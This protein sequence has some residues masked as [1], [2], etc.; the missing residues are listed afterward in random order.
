MLE[1]AV[2]QKIAEQVQFVAWWYANVSVNHGGSRAKQQVSGSRYLSYR[3]AERLT[4]MKQPRVSE[5]GKR[6]QDQE[7]YRR[8]L[9]GS[10]YRAAFLTSG[11]QYGGHGDYEWLTPPDIIEVVRKVFG[12][13]IGFDPCTCPEAQDIIQAEKV[14]S[15]DDDAL[16]Q[17]W[18]DL[19]FCN[20]PYKRGLIDL[21][22]DKLLHE[23]AAN[24]VRTAIMLSDDRTDSG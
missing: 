3:E 21:F 5:L 1:R 6:L 10:A 22:V 15:K 24:R 9:L 8:H 18:Q 4:G 20:L 2:D 13:K 16:T 17:N 7:K 14:F 12:G 19:A 11:I 23:I